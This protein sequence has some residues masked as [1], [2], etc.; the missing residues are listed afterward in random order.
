MTAGNLC[1]YWAYHH[2][3]VGPAKPLEVIN[4]DSHKKSESAL[5]QLRKPGFVQIAPPRVHRTLLYTVRI[6]P[7][8]CEAC[9]NRFFSR[10]I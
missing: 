4:V 9:G 8:R 2:G 1:A 7:F 6:V 3:I 5:P 10:A